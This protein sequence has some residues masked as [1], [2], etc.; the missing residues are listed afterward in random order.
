MK[1]WVIIY[2]LTCMHYD[3]T[4]ALFCRGANK[5]KQTL[6]TDTHCILIRSAKFRKEKLSKKV[7]KDIGLVLHI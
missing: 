6:T 5:K 3:V 1:G 7:F 4:T 2:Y